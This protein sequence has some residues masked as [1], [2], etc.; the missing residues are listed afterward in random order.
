MP[1]WLL[2]Y[3]GVNGKG[4][5]FS[6]VSRPLERT[7]SLSALHFSSP[8]RPVHSDTNSASLGSILATQQ[9]RAMSNSLIGTYKAGV[10]QVPA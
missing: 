10:N 6:A 9:F 7:K 5:L 8:A 1:T 2:D 3:V 4:K